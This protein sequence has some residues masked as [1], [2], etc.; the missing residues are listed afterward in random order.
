M[1]LSHV[2]NDQIVD[3]NPTSLKLTELNIKRQEVE[4]ILNKNPKLLS[5]IKKILIMIFY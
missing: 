1:V 5:K 4:R 2:C 3:V